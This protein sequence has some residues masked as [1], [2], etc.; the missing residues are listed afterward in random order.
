M[1]ETRTSLTINHDPT[2]VTY[3]VNRVICVMK[4]AKCF[5]WWLGAWSGV[6]WSRH[7]PAASLSHLLSQSLPAA[8]TTLTTTQHQHPERKYF[9][10]HVQS[11][12]NSQVVF[13]IYQMNAE[14]L[15]EI[16]LGNFQSE[17]DDKRKNA[18]KSVYWFHWILR[19]EKL[20]LV[21]MFVS[22]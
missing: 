13:H 7:S 18:L 8:A 4:M 16:K 14:I 2:E 6:S 3:S 5:W 15:V 21:K 22:V 19:F 1:T 10:F 9:N 11:N 20:Q 12:K 17:P